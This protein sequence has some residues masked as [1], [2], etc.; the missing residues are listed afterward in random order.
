MPRFRAIALTAAS[1]AALTLGAAAQ[2][3]APKVT[4]SHAFAIHGDVKYPPDF[5]HYSWV[6]PN[7]PKGGDVKFSWIGTFDS[8]NPF[9]LR[10]VPAIGAGSIYDTLMTRAADEPATDYC[11]ICETI[12][13]PEDR[14]WVIFN[15]RPEARFHDGKPIT[16]EDVIWTLETLKTKGHPRFRSYYA[17]VAKAEK[18]GPHKVRFTFSGGQNRELPGIIGEIPV[19][20]R[21]YWEGKD[22]EK[23]TLEAPLGSGAY[24]ID[25]FEPGRFIALRRVPD[26][27]GAK[28]PVNVGTS[29]FDTLRY[30]YFRDSTVALEAFKAGQYDIRPENS[31]KNWATAYDIPAV[32]SG[33][34]K[35]EIIP[36][37]DERVMQGYVFNT[38][39]P[40]FQDRRVRE[41][42]IYAW[43]FEWTNK[44]LF[45]GYYT[46]IDSYFGRDELSARGLPK[47]EELR[48][49]EQFRDKLPPEVFTKEYAPP[50][51]DGSGN[52]RDNQR[53]AT[54]LLRE[55]GWRIVDQKLVDAQGQQM[56]FEIMLDNPQFERIT[57]PFVENLRRLGID[58]RVRTVDTAQNQRREDEFDFDMTVWL[59]AQSE[60]PGNEQ[61]DYW[62]SAAAA[63][64]GS[65]NLPGIKDPVVD[66]LVEL[67][68]NAPDRDTLVAR[69]HALD[70]VLLWG[71]YVVP[72]FRLYARWIAYWDRFSHPPVDPKVGYAPGAWWVDAQKEAAL[73]QKRGQ[74][75]Q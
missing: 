48:V 31:A 57:L 66:A 22:F 10:G 54:R 5:K 67:V 39:R 70:R 42:I 52:W 43:D 27:W 8:L 56:S 62:S 25:S 59:V 4:V 16:P 41:A 60:S 50:K 11:L 20:P 72:H 63:T 32:T 33:L 21:H 28:L 3:P 49:L 53:I 55:A 26:Y 65:R 47:G 44:N 73:R 15:L 30:D 23:T 58:A 64:N 34:I 61:R 35:R 2:T 24:K 74:S 71:H 75:A 19:L 18:L 68:I 12:E 1:L 46:R 9:I 37:N 14:S 36:D 13:L 17:N 51:T 7:A 6:N 69:T 45:Y 29:N 38:R 40:F